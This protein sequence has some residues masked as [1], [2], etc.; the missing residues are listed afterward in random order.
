MK[1]FDATTIA[2]LLAP[3][4]TPTD[5]IE[6]LNAAAV[7]IINQPAVKSRFSELGADTIGSSSA[8]F[9]AYNKVDFAKWYKV[10]KDAN[11]K[12]D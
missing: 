8:E 9:A 5:I 4:G 1:G 12:V 11:I 6:R 3:A 7:K 2:G 10:V